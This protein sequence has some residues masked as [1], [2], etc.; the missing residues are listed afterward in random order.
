MVFQGVPLNAKW[1]YLI[2]KL[3]ESLGIVN[4][5]SAL[6]EQVSTGSGW[7]QR[8]T[9]EEVDSAGL[10]SMER[11][12][13][14]V[15]I[16]IDLGGLAGAE[17]MGNDDVTSF[18]YAGPLSEEV[19]GV[20]STAKFNPKVS[21]VVVVVARIMEAVVVLPCITRVVTSEQCLRSM[22]AVSFEFVGS[23]PFFTPHLSIISP[24]L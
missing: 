16:D 19:E 14:K 18:S 20:A 21:T 12:G 6:N 22:L 15:T 8:D 11:W 3:Q 23:D 4:Y 5:A 1:E 13:Y 24:C 17:P 10:Y 2:V 7:D 9:I